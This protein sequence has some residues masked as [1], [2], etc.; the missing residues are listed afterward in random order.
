MINI[1]NVQSSPAIHTY[2]DKDPISAMIRPPFI[3][4]IIQPL[5]MLTQYKYHMLPYKYPLLLPQHTDCYLYINVIPFSTLTDI[6]G[7][8]GIVFELF[9][10]CL[11]QHCQRVSVSLV[12]CLMFCHCYLVK[13]LVL[14][15]LALL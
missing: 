7:L 14:C 5:P 2:C 1:I 10:S 6:F 8:S 9:Q 11:E 3:Y 12:F 13:L 4:P 15:I